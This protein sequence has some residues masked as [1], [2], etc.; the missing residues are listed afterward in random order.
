MIGKIV[1]HYKILE[2]LGEGSMG[3]AYKAEDTQLKRTGRRS[4]RQEFLPSLSTVR[5][6]LISADVVI[7]LLDNPLGDPRILLLSRSQE[8]IP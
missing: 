3:V 4:N 5:K 8:A 6:S 2:K 7:P 1:S